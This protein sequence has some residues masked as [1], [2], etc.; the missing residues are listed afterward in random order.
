[1]ADRHVVRADPKRAAAVE[2]GDPDVVFRGESDVLAV[3]M[4]KP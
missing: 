4:R 1:M 2:R 3:K